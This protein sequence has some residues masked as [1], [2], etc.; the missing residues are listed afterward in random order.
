[1]IGGNSAAPTMIILTIL[2]KKAIDAKAERAA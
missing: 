2:L 1:M